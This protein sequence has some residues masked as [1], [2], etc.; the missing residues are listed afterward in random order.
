M[1]TRRKRGRREGEIMNTS[2]APAINFAPKLQWRL[3]HETDVAAIHGIHMEAL[4][5]LAPGLVRADDLA[6]FERHTRRDG[7]ILGCSNGAHEMIAY[8]VLGIDSATCAHLADLCALD[9]AERARFAI[10]DGVAA[11]QSCRGLRLHQQSIAQ[12]LDYARRVGRTLI[13]ATVAPRNTVSLHG[14]LKAKF[15]IKGFAVVYDG[16]DRLILTRDLEADMQADS[17]PRDAC[18][19]PIASP[20]GL[21]LV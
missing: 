1:H 7:V 15:E 8:G 9:P 4:I 5:G 12:R 11:L 19:E 2:V 18:R 10:L 14:L 20:Q 13:G 3:A 6:H 21:S 16:L 17:L